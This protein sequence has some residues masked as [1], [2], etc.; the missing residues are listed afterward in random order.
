MKNGFIQLLWKGSIFPPTHPSEKPQSHSFRDT[1]ATPKIATFPWTDFRPHHLGKE[2]CWRFIEVTPPA[3]KETFII[4]SIKT[5]RAF[6][7]LRISDKN[8]WEA[9]P[10]HREPNLK[11]DPILLI[12]QSLGAWVKVNF[13]S[14]FSLVDVWRVESENKPCMP[15]E[16]FT[17]TFWFINLETLMTDCLGCSCWFCL[18]WWDVE[19][20]E[21]FP[22]PRPRAPLA[23][24]PP[25]LEPTPWPASPRPAP[26][27]PVPRPPVCEPR[28]PLPLSDIV[29]TTLTFLHE[30][31]N[32]SHAHVDLPL[33]LLQNIV[34]TGAM[35][36]PCSGSWL[37]L[38]LRSY[39]RQLRWN[40]GAHH[41]RIKMWCGCG[42]C[43]TAASVSEQSYDSTSM[44]SW[45]I[46]AASLF[47]DWRDNIADTIVA[48]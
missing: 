25:P 19:E 16:N 48:T 13:A 44:A 28:L 40:G 24:G 35:Q 47:F 30:Q 31:F 17:W 23:P 2:L 15:P 27:P 42:Y 8:L 43:L 45:T 41:L 9:L 14:I 33:R 3:L 38:C 37:Q 39:A 6:N 32:S 21:E 29:N 1:P 22:R 5:A 34:R 11:V 12:F 26:L 18:S 46:Y 10:F 4:Y 20:R 36:F 7:W